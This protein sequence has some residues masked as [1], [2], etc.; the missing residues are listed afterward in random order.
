MWF[1]RCVVC[2]RLPFYVVYCVL[3]AE[4]CSLLVVSCAVCSSLFV[5][6]CCVLFALFVVGDLRCLLLVGC[7]LVVGCLLAC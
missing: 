2:G 1:V 3:R 7:L 6:V 4:W 5:I